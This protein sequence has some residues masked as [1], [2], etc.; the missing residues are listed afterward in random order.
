[1]NEIALDDALKQL[2]SSEEIRVRCAEL[3]EIGER[4]NLEHFDVRTERLAVVAQKVAEVT[5]SRYP[6]LNI[7]IHSR[8]RHF[9]VS[10]INRW[11]Q[12]S[13]NIEPFERART[14]LDLVIPSVLL[15]AGA[16][17]SWRYREHQTGNVYSR[18]EGLAIASF[19]MFSLGLFSSDPEQPLRTD[20]EA[21][22]SFDVDKLG[23]AFQVGPE[24][25]MDG[26]EGRAQLLHSLGNL[27]KNKPA[28]FGDPPRL[29]TLVDYLVEIM[30]SPNAHDVLAILIELLNEIWPDRIQLNGQ[31]LGDVWHHSAIQRSDDTNELVP[32]HKLTQWLTYSLIEPLQE[33]G[34]GLSKT[35]ALTGL[36][37]YRN[38]GLFLDLDVL[39]PRNSDVYHENHP[40]DSELVVEWRALTLAL[41][42]RLAPLIRQELNLSQHSL[43]LGA[44]L[45]GG[46]WATGRQLAFEKRANGDPPIT[47]Q[48]NGTIF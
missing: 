6:N 37:E 31:N 45:E 27:L 36:A 2:R 20:A 34:I 38:G 15:D 28:I 22:V 12:L 7:P 21:L 47:V 16:G 11:H 1:M 18:S 17:S 43:P 10:G 13:S 9:E 44:I 33:A 32:F 29:G 30:P 46:T 19:D 40:P 42:D 4:G 8:W 14:A 24:N 26:I 48:S 3:L 39:S 35:E 5:R 25:L 23:Q 41:L